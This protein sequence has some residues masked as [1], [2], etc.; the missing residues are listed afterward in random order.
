MIEV[1]AIPASHFGVKGQVRISLPEANRISSE[2]V[3]YVMTWE[4][5]ET[6]RNELNKAL[7]KVKF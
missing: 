6:L 7:E 4:E 2:S 1:L 3:I 5:A